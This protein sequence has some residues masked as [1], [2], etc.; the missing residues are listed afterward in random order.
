MP[1]PYPSFRQLAA[2]CR[3]QAARRGPPDVARLLLELAR[4]YEAQAEAEEAC[5]RRL[6]AA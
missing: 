4:E 2:I 6:K 1:S 3:T 5:Q